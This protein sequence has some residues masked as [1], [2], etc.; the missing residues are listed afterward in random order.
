MGRDTRQHDDILKEVTTLLEET[1]PVQ[2]TA[3]LMEEA[4]KVTEPK[5]VLTANSTT[6]ATLP[7][8]NSDNRLKWTDKPMCKVR[9]IMELCTYTMMATSCSPKLSDTRPNWG[10]SRSPKTTT[11][12][13]EQ[14]CSCQFLRKSHSF[15]KQTCSILLETA[16][17]EQRRLRPMRLAGHLLHSDPVGRLAAAT[18]GRRGRIKMTSATSQRKKQNW[19]SQEGNA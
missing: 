13:N 14:K 4:R 11:T 6:P 15:W 12:P 7:P 18:P 10:L 19:Q 16:T 8:Q 3:K 5:T 17:H 2:D 9:T 1:T